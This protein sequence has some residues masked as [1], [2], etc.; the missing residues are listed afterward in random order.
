QADARELRITPEPVGENRERGRSADRAPGGALREERVGVNAREPEQ[1]GLQNLVAGVEIETL[2]DE[3]VLLHEQLNPDL[4]RAA[5]EV[6]LGDAD[7]EI[8][9]TVARRDVEFQRLAVTEQVI[10]RVADP[11]EA[12]ADARDAAVELNLLPPALLHLQVNFH[13]LITRVGARGRIFLLDLLKEAELIEAQDR[14]VPVPLVVR[15]AFVDQHLA[16]HHHVARVGVAD[17][18]EAAQREL[19]ALV[20][21]ERD[22]D[23]ALLVGL[24]NEFRDEFRAGLDVAEFAV[25]ILDVLVNAFLNRLGRRV[26]ADLEARDGRDDAGLEARHTFLIDLGHLVATADF[27]GD[28]D[29]QAGPAA[30]QEGDREAAAHRARAL[31]L[32]LTDDRLEVALVAEEEAQLPL[33]VGFEFI[34]EVDVLG[35]E[36]REQ[37]GL[38]D[39]F[40]RVAQLA[41]RE[42][43][44]ARKDDLLDADAL[45]FT[46]VVNQRDGG[47]RDVFDLDVNGG[48]G[49]ALFGQQFAQ[50]VAGGIDLRRVELGILADPDAALLEARQDVA[51]GR[52]F[53]PAILDVANDRI[54]ADLKGDDFAPARAVLHEQPGFDRV[55]PA[56]A[57]DR[58]QIAAQLGLAVYVSLLA[59]HVIE[60]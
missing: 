57:E 32:R 2:P 41:L 10:G 48:V 18:F 8:F 25:K 3:L 34:L 19:L 26:L 40:H 50:H 47:G 23:L 12:A 60:N 14:E 53:E 24:I 37:P 38:L 6:R 36:A 43:G 59:L 58:L 22:F 46:D 54:L 30:A 51:L 28:G 42:S 33:Q 21:F 49:V 56:G 9:L 44:L 1:A 7:E 17:E 20:H 27:D 5:Q 52:R 55:E 4:N 13:R 11:E 29:A 39:V 15:V 35:G 16:P 45:A 31:D